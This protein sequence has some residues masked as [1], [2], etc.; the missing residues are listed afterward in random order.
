MRRWLAPADAVLQQLAWWTAVLSA[1]RGDGVGAALAAVA[2]AAAH[3]ALR[4]GERRWIAIS[5][6][7]AALYGLASDTL[8]AAAGFLAF[9]GEL[10]GIAATSPAWMVGLWASFG[11]ALTASLRGATRWR[12]PAVAAA[13]GIA[14]PLAYRAG[15]ALGA[16]AFTGDVALGTAAVALQWALGIPLL[17]AVARLTAREDE[18]LAGTAGVRWAR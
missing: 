17:C 2:P 5:A 9:S 10:P 4:R 12:A 1:A 13:A 14:G 3:L 7:V 11:A 18:D 6:G 15:A 16:I 8:V